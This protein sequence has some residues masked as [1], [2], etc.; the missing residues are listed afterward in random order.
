MAIKIIK[1]ITYLFVRSLLHWVCAEFGWGN[2]VVA[3]VFELKSVTKINLRPASLAK[4]R[5]RS[6]PNVTFSNHYSVILI[7]QCGI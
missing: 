6:R 4:E 1:Q 7:W 2:W 3:L 5:V